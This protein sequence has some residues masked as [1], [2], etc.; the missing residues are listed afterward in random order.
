[1][2]E[3]NIKQKQEYLDEVNR[4]ISDVI[5][6]DHEYSTNSWCTVQRVRERLSFLEPSF[7]KNA[8]FKKKYPFKK[9]LY[10]PNFL[11]FIVLLA[12]LFLYIPTAR[13]CSWSPNS[14]YVRTVYAQFIWIL[15]LCVQC[16][17]VHCKQFLILL[18]FVTFPE[19]VQFFIF[20]CLHNYSMLNP[21][22]LHSSWYF[23]FF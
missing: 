13:I 19:C 20:L 10:I 6:E 12:V 17:T 4:V 23:F 8:R 5:S 2:K 3:K 11:V 16:Y 22:Y 14:M 9:N 1:M 18:L 7:M 21:F 15:P